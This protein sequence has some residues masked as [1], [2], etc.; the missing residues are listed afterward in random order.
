MQNTGEDVWAL[1]IDSIV[2]GIGWNIGGL[3]QMPPPLGLGANGSLVVG[4][5]EYSDF[6]LPPRRAYWNWWAAKYVAALLKST[7][8]PNPKPQ[9]PTVNPNHEPHLCVSD[10]PGPISA[11]QSDF[12]IDWLLWQCNLYDCIRGVRGVF[13]SPHFVINSCAASGCYFNNKQILLKIVFV[14]KICPGNS[15]LTVRHAL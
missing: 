2:S 9:Y 3:W 10:D 11:T 13:T 8:I 15:F 14:Y 4:G 6:Q 1:G 12:D 5:P 7:P